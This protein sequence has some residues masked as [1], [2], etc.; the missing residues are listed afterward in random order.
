MFSPGDQSDGNDENDAG[1]GANDE[2]SPVGLTE[3]RAF[4]TD[5]SA[6][7]L[8]DRRPLARPLDRLRRLKVTK[9]LHIFKY[10]T[11]LLSFFFLLIIIQI[12]QEIIIK[13]NRNIN[14]INKSN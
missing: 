12:N 4:L 9:D 14:T 6:R 1:Y 3:M 2:T 5:E 13:I 8:R 10:Q 7:R 11:R